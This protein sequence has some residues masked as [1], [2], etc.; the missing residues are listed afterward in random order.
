MWSAGEEEADLELAESGLKGEGAW[1]NK[2]DAQKEETQSR[3]CKPQDRDEP[4]KGMTFAHLECKYLAAKRHI[5][6]A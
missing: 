4:T 1:H 5:L 6:W 3:I 2:N